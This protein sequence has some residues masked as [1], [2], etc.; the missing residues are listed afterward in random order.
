M[1]NITLNIETIQKRI[2]EIKSKSGKRTF[3][4]WVKEPKLIETLHKRIEH[5][6]ELDERCKDWLELCNKMY[7]KNENK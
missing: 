3:N 4:Q 6:K 7:K 2:A 5:L 1:E